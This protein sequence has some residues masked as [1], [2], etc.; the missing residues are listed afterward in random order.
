ML[1]WVMRMRL[2]VCSEFKIV[3]NAQ[4]NGDWGTEERE[5]S[6]PYVYSSGPPLVICANHLRFKVQEGNW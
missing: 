2:E 4:H 5:G 6:F 3:R 1:S